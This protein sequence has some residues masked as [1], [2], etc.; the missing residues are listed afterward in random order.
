M[1]LSEEDFF[2][3]RS[4]S[5]NRELMRVFKDIGLVAQ[6]GSGMSRILKVYDRSIF[7]ISENFMVVTFKF[8][9]KSAIKIG[10]K[11]SA[12]KIGNK[13]EKYKAEII[14]FLTRKNTASSSEIAEVI[15]LKSSRTR[16][17]L[18]KMVVDGLIVAEGEK[19]NRLYR[20]ASS[21]KDS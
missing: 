13:Y 9:E 10:D 2:N 18:G 21:C 6:L 17:Y 15:G 4:M 11:K 7:E 19:K 1:G 5:R 16:D 12:I 8:S 20:L 3:C 14:E